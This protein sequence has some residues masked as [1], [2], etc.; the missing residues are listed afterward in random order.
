MPVSVG[1]VSVV[2][3]ISDGDMTTEDSLASFDTARERIFGVAYRML[4]SVTDAEDI[5]QE[6]WLRWERTDRTVV[7]E[8]VAFL[9]T[10]AT[11]LAIN[12]A[13][14]AQARRTSYV[15]PW[16]P[17]PVDTSADPALG[18][19]RA[20]ALE[21]AVLL[22]LE[23]LTPT[24][25]AA[26]ILREAFEYPY[27][28]VALVLQTTE[29]NARQLAARARAHLVGERRRPVERSE[30]RRLLEAFV[31]AA[32]GGDLATLESLLAKD[33]VS[34]SDGG[35]NAVAARVP[36]IG[37]DRVAPFLI[38]MAASFGRG[39]EL[40]LG[41]ANGAPAAYFTRNGAPEGVL[42]LETSDG[43]IERLFIVMNPNKLSA[44]AT[45]PR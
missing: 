12:A 34:I 42:A 36:I 35:G 26:Y 1:S 28:E 5:V 22:V 44:F 10:T 24:E 21:L 23:K 7:R 40:W 39:I 17:E 19:I 41:E 15:G 31:L 32:Q 27:R 11:R 3:H 45:P 33:V 6:T 30:Q 25:R 8:P 18:A 38:K 14:S 43:T 20:E 29:A 4:G 16:L 37:R 13:T 9:T 2:E